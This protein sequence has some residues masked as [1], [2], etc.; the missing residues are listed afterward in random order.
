MCGIFGLTSEKNYKET[1]KVLATAARRRGK[2]SSGII[3]ITKT[4]LK[5]FRSDCDI[6]N[7]ISSID[8]ED[9]EYIFGHSRLKTNGNAD[10]QP[11]VGERCLVLHNGII[12]N[13]K[14]IW[15]YLKA[16]PKLSVDTEALVTFIDEAIDANVSTDELME[17]ILKV[18]KGTINS[19]ILIPKRNQICLISNHGSLYKSEIGNNLVVFSEKYPITKLTK[20][21]IDNL[22]Q[23]FEIFQSKINLNN[24]KVEIS[25]IKETQQ[26]NIL[27]DI[28][29]NKKYSGLPE[30]MPMALKRCTKC[31]L[32]ET[33][34]YIKFN[35][36]GV[37]NYC[38]NYESKMS[39]K[40]IG[41]LNKLLEPYRRAHGQD[42]IVPFSGGRDSCYGLHLIVKEL[43]MK[44]VTYTYDWGMVTD[45]ARRNISR[46]CSQL[47]VEN[48]VIAADI[49]KKRENIRK[50]LSAFL[51]HPDLGMVSILTA[52]DKHFFRYLND[53]QS[54]TGIS[55]NLWGTNPLEV[56]HFKAGFLG[57][58]PEFEN[59]NVY[60]SGW[61]R[62]L[63]YQRKRLAAM[64]K[65]KGYFN[66]SIFDT[67]SGEYY[68]S[69][70][71]RTDYYHIFDY[72]QWIERDVDECLLNTYDWETAPDSLSTWR[73][74]DGTA[75]IY[76]YIYY[77]IAGF[78]EHDTFRS[79]QIREGHISRDQALQIIQEENE[80]RWAN[81]EWY[82]EIVGVDFKET[83]LAIERAKKIWQQYEH[84]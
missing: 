32:P 34:P 19:I 29:Y 74:G 38:E 3:S 68:R 7:L 63:S 73:I 53:V 59:Q 2:D 27:A 78:T 31:I 51:K 1:L 13:E 72:W 11:I 8:L 12:V 58:K 16:E 41:E 77:T 56:T 25:D 18:F 22:K 69:I 39:V 64:V 54:E 28:T 33:M 80:P 35:S 46:M 17:N 10:N 52:G 36:D 61:S 15:S 70:S 21:K 84:H 81:I 49:R 4:S 47:G 55:L 76:N 83:V 14:E 37:C 23:R 44:P 6:N 67:L 30:V 26:L 82:C 24:L 9:S 43:D 20:N 62:Q 65:S 60:S 40:P 5:V 79:N 48:I 75:A 42:V 57:I 71:K 50:N 66:F 45:L